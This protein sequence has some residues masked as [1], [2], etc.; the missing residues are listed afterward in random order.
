MELQWVTVPGREEGRAEAGSS[1]PI[2]ERLL[3]GTQSLLE[4][5]AQGEPSWCSPESP[6]PTLE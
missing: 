3:W 2:V 4:A 1:V 5:R 6:A